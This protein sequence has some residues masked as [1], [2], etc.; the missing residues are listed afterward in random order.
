LASVLSSMCRWPGVGSSETGRFHGP[1]DLDPGDPGRHSG[2][3]PGGAGSFGNCSSEWGL[4]AMSRPAGQERTPCVC[5][6]E[7]A[8]ETTLE[9]TK[10]LFQRLW[11][12][13]CR[14]PLS[15]PGDCKNSEERAELE[16]FLSNWSQND[17]SK[18]MVCP[19]IPPPPGKNHLVFR[20]PLDL[21]GNWRIWRGRGRPGKAA[22]SCI[23]EA[24]SRARTKR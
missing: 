10:D 5:P 6:L 11:Q 14:K 15:G 3:C 21:E 1:S 8:K 24:V 22:G 9:D 2:M 17:A 19:F 12:Q 18:T 16:G 20:F 4:Q 7:P 13:S 23:R